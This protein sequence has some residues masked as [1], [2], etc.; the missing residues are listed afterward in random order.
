MAMIYFSLSH[1][2]HNTIISGVASFG[3]CTYSHKGRLIDM[4]ISPFEAA[5]MVIDAAEGKITGRTTIQKIIYFGTIKNTVKTTYRPHYY[6]P[7]SAD[8]AGPSRQL[9][10]VILSMKQWIPATIKSQ[11]RPSSGNGIH[12]H[13]MKKAI[14][15]LSS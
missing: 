1:R 9:L 11:M 2:A 14:K 13:S 15:L 3:T 12:I 7:Y 5:M 8:V 10:H 6:G 4:T